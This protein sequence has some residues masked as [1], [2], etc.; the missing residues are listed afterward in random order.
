MAIAKY[1]QRTRGTGRRG[2][3]AISG[4]IT[5]TAAGAIL[6]QTGEL[7]TAAKNA[8]AGRYDIV[9]DRVYRTGS[10][11]FNGAM[12]VRPDTTAFG[13]TSANMIQGQVAQSAAV[14]ATL[15]GILASSGADT[16]VKSGHII[17]YE[18]IA[19]EL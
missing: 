9:F 12:L 5:I 15:Q 7:S 11:R 1:K 18:F 8:A 3:V 2:E 13:N 6:S 10:I 14:H 19:Q 17:H 16:D 4:T